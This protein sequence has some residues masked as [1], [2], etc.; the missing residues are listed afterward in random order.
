MAEHGYYILDT[1][2]TCGDCA[3]W[4]APDSAGYVVNL[5]DAG[6][7]D[8]A[9]VDGLWRDTDIAVP[10]DVATEI[11]GRHVHMERL[12]ARGFRPPPPPH[13]PPIDL[14]QALCVN[15]F[16]GDFGGPADRTF[17]DH[18]VTARQDHECCGFACTRG[19]R[20]GEKHRVMVSKVDDEVMQHRWCRT[21]CIDQINGP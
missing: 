21:C 17:R 6:V 19:V 8:Q 18:I 3:V 20:K 5:D 15:P 2:S 13:P 7:Y 12:R 16:D 9:F 1:R 11:A 14:T 4:W 10:A